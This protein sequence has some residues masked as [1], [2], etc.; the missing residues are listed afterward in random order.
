MVDGGPTLIQHQVDISLNMLNTTHATVVILDTVT[1]SRPN[2]GI[3]LGRCRRCW[4]NIETTLVY[5]A[6]LFA[7]HVNT[8]GT[9][10]DNSF[11]PT[12]VVWLRGAGGPRVVVITAA[13]HARVRGSVPGVGGLKETKMFLPHPR[14]QVS[15]VGSLR[16]REIACTASD[17]QVA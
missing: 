6:C 4:I 9:I 7:V 5:I 3:R 14:V 12:P 17:R 15:I 10:L 2:A 8:A 13:F 16:D 11:V 1:K